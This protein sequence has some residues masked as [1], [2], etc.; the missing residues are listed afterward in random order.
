MSLVKQFFRSSVFKAGKSMIDTRLLRGGPCTHKPLASSTLAR[1]RLGRVHV[2]LLLLNGLLSIVVPWSAL[3]AQDSGAVD[4]TASSALTDLST[5]KQAKPAIDSLLQSKPIHGPLTLPDSEEQATLGFYQHGDQVYALYS[6]PDYQDQ[7]KPYH[8]LIDSF[9]DAHITAVFFQDLDG[10]ERNEMVVMY[11]NK[12]GQH[13]RAYATMDG[14][15]IA[16][17]AM[18]AKLDAIAPTLKPFTVAA[19]RKALR[20]LQPQDYRINYDLPTDSSPDIKAVLRGEQQSSAQPVGYLDEQGY[21][22]DSAATATFAIIRYPALTRSVTTNDGQVL[23]YVLTQVLART[24]MCQGEE[25]SFSTLKIGYMR[26]DKVPAIFDYDSEDSLVNH[27]PSPK[28]EYDGPYLQFSVN[29]C[30]AI[31]LVHGNYVQGKQQGRWEYINPE[32]GGV[33]ESGNYVND[34]R[35]GEWTQWDLRSNS[36]WRGQYKDNLK[37]GLWLLTTDTP[38]PEVLARENYRH[39]LLNGPAERYD[40]ITNDDPQNTASASNPLR[41]LYK[42]EYRDEKK[43]GHWLEMVDGKRQES[44]YLN[45]MLHGVKKIYDADNV[46]IQQSTYQ[47]GFLQ[48]EER[49]FYPSG[50][51]SQV[52]H[53]VQDQPDGEEFYF[54]DGKVKTGPLWYW[55]NWKRIAPDNPNANCDPQD[56]DLCTQAGK[57][58]AF[59]IL[60]GEQREYAENGRLISLYHQTGETKR[61]NAYS[62]NEQGQLYGV[63]PYAHG[64]EQGVSTLYDVNKKESRLVQVLPM[65]DNRITGVNYGFDSNSNHLRSIGQACQKPDETY[66]G[67]P[68]RWNNASASC[69]SQIYFHPNGQLNRITW[70]DSDREITEVGYGEEGDLVVE[71]RY[72]GN[73]V[74]INNRYT[75]YVDREYISVTKYISTNTHTEKGRTFT[76]PL[77]S[78]SN[79]VGYEKDYSSGRLL[80][81]SIYT[82]SDTYCWRRYATDG[83]IQRSNG[84]CNGIHMPLIP[85]SGDETL[86]A[87][88]VLNDL[89]F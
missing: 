41:L 62:F 28:P 9:T 2:S 46:L 87:E 69:G 36:N 1:W 29:D 32:D 16:L 45:D 58:R 5:A 18:Q 12:Q 79:G 50:Q 64:K 65:W 34:Q 49:R 73:N 17:T 76:V 25:S 48:G 22:A 40:L 55:K 52:T 85:A 89:P 86:G 60:S 83:S 21:P 39:G 70:K 59:S 63:T 77:S 57:P 88:K 43:I 66:A 31:P 24:G 15:Y 74:F 19:S 47:H 78:P 82:G 4:A 14:S 13:L 35:Q 71:Q 27:P 11:Q 23:S 75:R 53:Y 84:N 80:D 8:D 61:G 68:Y 81:E 10:G 54:Y 51:L 72:A 20:T 6:R 38:T 44:E 33:Q 3:A 7:S 26:T 67:Q 37:E 42:G 30:Y 56:H